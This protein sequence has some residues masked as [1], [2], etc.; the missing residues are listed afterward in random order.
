MTEIDI[1]RAPEVTLDRDLLE[2]IYHHLLIGTADRLIAMDDLDRDSTEFEV[3][4]SR[5]DRAV[6]TRQA[7]RDALDQADFDE[8][9]RQLDI[10]AA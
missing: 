2:D 7:L 9:L 8:G 1:I 3:A 4:A 10:A 5:Y 6:K